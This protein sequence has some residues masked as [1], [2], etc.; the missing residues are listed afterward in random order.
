[1]K[2][3]ELANMQFLESLLNVCEVYVCIIH[4]DY[5]RNIFI[6]CHTWYIHNQVLISYLD[7]LVAMSRTFINFIM[8]DN[9]NQ[10]PINI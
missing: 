10:M 4:T 7:T 3:S 1:M 2:N 9:Y 5:I 8:N 6:F